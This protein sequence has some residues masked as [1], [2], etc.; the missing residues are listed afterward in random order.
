[1]STFCV[2]FSVR[3]GAH[4]CMCGMYVICVRVC[5]ASVS[6]VLFHIAD[7]LSIYL[8]F[9]FY[10]YPIVNRAF[11]FFFSFLFSSLSLIY[12]YFFFILLLLRHS[13]MRFC[14][15]V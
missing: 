4:V 9:T 3:V 5:Y 13:I 8:K 14:T 1:M 6:S 11:F 2:P 7:R 10:K 15:R 12:I